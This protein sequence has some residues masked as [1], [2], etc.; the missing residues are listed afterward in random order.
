MPQAVQSALSRPKIEW[1]FTNL[2]HDLRTF[3]NAILG[4][5]ALWIE[6][7]PVDS[8]PRIAESLA[9]MHAQGEWL[10]QQVNEL[11]A[12]SRLTDPA[13]TAGL[14]ERMRSVLNARIQAVI[15]STDDLRNAVNA[16]P[17]ELLA[18]LGK[19]E[20][21]AEAL[22]AMLAGIE[23]VV[24]G[25]DLLI[26]EQSTLQANVQAAAGTGSRVLVV[27]DNEANRDVLSRR[28]QREGYAVSLAEDGAKALAMLDG[29]SFDLVLLDIMMPQMNGY[30]VLQ[31]IRSETRWYDLPV[32]MISSVDEMDSIVRCI[33][34]GAEDYLPKPFNPVLLRARVGACLEKK[35]LRDERAAK[36]KA[37]AERLCWELDTAARVQQRLLPVQAPQVAGLDLAGTCLPA[38]KVGGDYFDHLLLDDSHLGLVMADVKGKGIPAALLMATLVASLRSQARP[39]IDNLARLM[40]ILNLQIHDWTETSNFASLFYGCL[41]LRNRQLRYVNAGH[42]MPLLVRGA[43]Q[44]IVA[45]PDVGGPVLGVLP[46][47]P[48]EEGS[49]QLE[50]G[51][52]LLAYTDGVTE[53]FNAQDEEFGEERLLAAVLQNLEQPSAAICTSVA[54]SV[55]AWSTGVPQSDDITLLAM[56]LH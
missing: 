32:I 56:K 38:R 36:Q 20:T 3:L 37:E 41:D 4:Y 22:L 39:S 51:D 33:E 14:G 5:T 44:E 30:D 53:A 45:I 48:F 15:A 43:K 21:A 17:Q 7:P 11:M 50:T 54:D 16:G 26:A 25:N 18:D 24:G 31:R 35:R 8:S 34:M 6:D 47:A 13:Y 55:R 40:K 52:L 10:L 9:D 28:L 49:V 12:P 2:R 42:L 27:D 46:E 23:S 1:A 19:V 29:E